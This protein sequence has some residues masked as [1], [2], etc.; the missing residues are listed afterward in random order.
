[1]GAQGGSSLARP[2]NPIQRKGKKFSQNG[3]ISEKRTKIGKYNPNFLT[4]ICVKGFI[5]DIITVF[6]SI[7]Q[8]S[9][10]LKFITFFNR[11]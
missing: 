4:Y 9:V 6:H 10:R 3:Q 2:D 8:K 1:M 11:K 5:C 7:I